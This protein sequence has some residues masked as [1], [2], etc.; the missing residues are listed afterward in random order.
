MDDNLATAEHD[1]IIA[2]E[3]ELRQHGQLSEQAFN[4]T[5]TILAAAPELPLSEVRES[6]KVA[7]ALLMRLSNDLRCSALL[8]LRGY[9]VQALGLVASIYEVAYTIA[10]IGC[11]D[12]RAV[13]WIEHDDPTRT[14]SEMRTLTRDGLTKLGVPNPDEQSAIEYRVYRQLCWAKHARPVF[15]KHFGHVL[16]N[17]N[18][19]ALNGPDTSEDAI[20]AAWFALEQGVALMFIALA[21]FAL[22]H[23]PQK[24]QHDVR[25]LID[26]IGAGRK[27]LEAEAQS[28]WGTTDPFPGKW[29]V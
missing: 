1:A 15:Q 24:A 19:I 20:L 3:G 13:K 8:A 16:E 28:R 27:R 4:T 14:F 5:G 12:A 22:H 23:L 29:R 11:D 7:V 25:P 26:A 21:S 9:P 17:G 2:L 6:R 18:V 10:A